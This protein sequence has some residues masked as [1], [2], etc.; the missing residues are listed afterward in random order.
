MRGLMCGTSLD[1]P[2]DLSDTASEEDSTEHLT[3]AS[4]DSKSTARIA[5]SIS[6][7][8]CKVCT[9]QHSPPI[10]MCCESC[11]NVLEP[12]SFESENTWIC[13]SSE[14]HGK[15]IGYVNSVDVGRCGLCGAKRTG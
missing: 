11:N 2:Y 9:T 12:E 6:S 14:C 8:V 10:P 5:P 7:V 3:R 1:S 13:R 4:S 15:E